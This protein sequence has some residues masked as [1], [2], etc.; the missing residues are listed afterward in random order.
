LV[1]SD[2]Q[3][4]A[5]GM[6]PFFVIGGGIG[7]FSSIFVYWLLESLFLLSVFLFLVPAALL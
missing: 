3:G 1:S 4:V 6:R 7:G 2:E 5:L